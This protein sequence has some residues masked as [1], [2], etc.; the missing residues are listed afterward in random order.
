MDFYG[1]FHGELGTTLHGNGISLSS[2]LN[3]STGYV[4]LWYDQSGYNCDLQQLTNNNQPTID[5]NGNITYNGVNTYLNNVASTPLTAA[6]K[7]YTFMSTWTPT[8]TN[9][10]CIF[11]QATTGYPSNSRASMVQIGANYGFSGISND[12]YSL[13]IQTGKVRKSVMICNHNLTTNNILLHDNNSV[14][15]IT[16]NSTPTNLSV[17]TD[18]CNIGRNNNSAEYFTGNIN[19]FIIFNINLIIKESQVY[20]QPITAPCQKMSSTPKTQ[21]LGLYKDP[22]PIPT[23]WII[24]FD[25]QML[26]NITSGT[27]IS[28]WGGGTAFNSPTYFSSGG[29]G[30]QPYVNF[31]RANSQYLNFGSKTFN[32]A[33]NGGFTAIAYLQFTGSAGNFERIFDFG[34]GANALS[35]IEF[36]RDGTLSDVYFSATNSSGTSYGNCGLVAN[37]SNSGNWTVFAVRYTASNRLQELFVN[38]ILNA[39]STASAAWTNRTKTNTYIGKDRFGTSAYLNANVAGLYVYDR[40]LTNTEMSSITN[41]LRYSTISTLPRSIADYTQVYK[42]GY[43]QTYGF[44]N[45]RFST[46]FSGNT[47][48][49]INVTDVPAPPLSYC[50]WVY[51]INSNYYTIVGLSDSNRNGSGWGIQVDYNSVANTITVYCALPTAWSSFNM[52]GVNNNAWY[53]VCITLN[54]NY[55][56]QGY[57]NGTYVNSVTGHT[58][59]TI[60]LPIVTI[61]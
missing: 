29:D 38:G 47:S 23:N 21:L 22:S 10:G 59:V 24:A 51:T 15:K 12:W 25:M 2:W 54:T 32:I 30:Q 49:Y 60:S 44:R 53:H 52:S 37:S 28:S 6:N 61:L 40:S 34:S 42:S 11:D 36:S 55:T 5:L 45:N 1:N 17:G 9:S 33:T 18:F 46:Y 20:F 26:S 41:H 57:L 31:N 56:V 50:F 16:T 13:P 4:T 19:E 8:S 58:T 3:G 7:T 43:V 27:G 35:I 14:Y 39:S 48:D